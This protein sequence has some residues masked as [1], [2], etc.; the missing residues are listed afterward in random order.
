MNK[1]RDYSA[2][3]NWTS[4]LDLA[5]DYYGYVMDRNQLEP[6]NWDMPTQF[7]AAY[8]RAANMKAWSQGIEVR[9]IASKRSR[10]NTSPPLPPNKLCYSW[11][12]QQAYREDPYY[13]YYV[14]SKCDKDY[15]VKSYPR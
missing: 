6:S 10:K 11:N 8:C 13:Y 3:Y 1:I 14:Y 5:L 15:L 9:G 2:T 12:N 4:I 7:K